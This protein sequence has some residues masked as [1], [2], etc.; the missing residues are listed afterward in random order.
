MIRLVLPFVAALSSI[1]NSPES[2]LH[3][4]NDPYRN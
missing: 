1:Y 3:V 2:R 4:V